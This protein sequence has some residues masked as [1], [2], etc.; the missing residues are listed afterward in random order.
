MSYAMKTPVTKTQVL[1]LV[2][3]GHFMIGLSVFVNVRNLNNI[4][5]RMLNISVSHS[6]WWALDGGE[7]RLV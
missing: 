4:D 7:E 2:E 5:I 3:P 6:P 1:D